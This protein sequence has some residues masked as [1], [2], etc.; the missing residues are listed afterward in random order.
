[1]VDWQSRDQLCLM[2]ARPVVFQGGQPD[3]IS[4]PLVYL[5]ACLRATGNITLFWHEPKYAV[6]ES[7]ARKILYTV[8]VS[9]WAYRLVTSAPTVCETF[10]ISSRKPLD[11]S[12]L[13]KNC[14]KQWKSVEEVPCYTKNLCLER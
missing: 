7:G 11:F 10:A 1:M 8:R 5:F 14:A 9:A 6:T 3:K 4:A 13:Q 12:D 2:Y